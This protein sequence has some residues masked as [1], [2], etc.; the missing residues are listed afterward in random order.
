MLMKRKLQIKQHIPQSDIDRFGSQHFLSE[1]KI[2]EELKKEFQNGLHLKTLNSNL[3]DFIST[4]K[5]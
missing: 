4:F 1:E 2:K 5:K 3:F